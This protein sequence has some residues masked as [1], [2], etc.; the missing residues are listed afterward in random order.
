MY[1]SSEIP[2]WSPEMHVNWSLCLKLYISAPEDMKQAANTF[3]R[4]SM[5]MRRLINDHGT[6]ACTQLYSILVTDLN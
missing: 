4:V 3:I 1:F 6:S 2:N 5:W